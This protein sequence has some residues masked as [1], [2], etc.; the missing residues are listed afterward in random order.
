[1]SMPPE[2]SY[3]WVELP[4][5]RNA[6]IFNSKMWAFFEYKARIR[7]KTARQLVAETVVGG[8]YELLKNS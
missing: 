2:F 1:M 6:L 5:G 7:E 4:D 8:I 3:E